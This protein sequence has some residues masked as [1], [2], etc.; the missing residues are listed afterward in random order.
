LPQRSKGD[1]RRNKKTM[2]LEI[3][4]MQRRPQKKIPSK[5][6]ENNRMHFL[7]IKSLPKKAKLSLTPQKSLSFSFTETLEQT[8]KP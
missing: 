3:R 6:A 1:R 7:H 2:A 5:E 8:W 4:G